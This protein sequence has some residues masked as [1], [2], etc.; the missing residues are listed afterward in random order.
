MYVKA[1]VISVLFFL[2]AS[3]AQ[4][5]P[6]A[7]SGI[8][9]FNRLVVYG[10]VVLDDGSPL[11][12]T[13]L[14]ESICNEYRHVEARTDTSGHFSFEMGN[15]LEK[16]T[17]SPEVESSP[18]QMGVPEVHNRVGDSVAC[19]RF[20]RGTYHPPWNWRMPFRRKMWGKSYY[21]VLPMRGA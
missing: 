10:I 6:P 7:S 18:D 2:T 15:R 17:D 3:I 11:T 21:T 20:C 16:T 13:V 8:G 4:Q 14:I 12:D 1:S 9:P 5:R 19:R